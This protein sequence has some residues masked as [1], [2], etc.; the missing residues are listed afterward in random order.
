MI[1]DLGKQRGFIVFPAVC[2]TCVCCIELYILYTV[3]NTTQCQCLINI[4]KDPC[5]IWSINLPSLYKGCKTE[6]LKV[7]KSKLR[8][9]L[10][11][12]FNRDYIKRLLYTVSE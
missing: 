1:Q 7:I 4:R 8:R 11:K 5:T 6:I 2:Y 3:R 12:S 9:N 10:G